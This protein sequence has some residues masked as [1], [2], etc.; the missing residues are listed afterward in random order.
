MPAHGRGIGP[1]RVCRPRRLD[2]D[3]A[4]GHIPYLETVTKIAE[5]VTGDGSRWELTAESHGADHVTWL[6][7]TTPD[8]HTAKGGYGDS[9]VQEGRRLGLYT[10]RDD[11]GPNRA[12][13]RV[14][15][16][17]ATVRVNLSDGGW[18]SLDLTPHP[19]D[20]AAQVGAF[21]Y[22]RALEIRNILLLDC[23]GEQLEDHSPPSHPG[24]PRLRPT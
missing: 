1:T 6:R 15:N 19:I 10:G 18:E 8:G 20:T 14:S 4:A 3:T 7:V 22:P 24:P 2:G 17:V 11:I 21:I 9:S 5:G 13:I 16:D 12:I 23:D